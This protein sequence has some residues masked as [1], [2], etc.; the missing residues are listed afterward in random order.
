MKGTT[1]TVLLM[2]I[3][4]LV[5][6]PHLSEYL[7]LDL[8]LILCLIAAP[9]VFE[10]QNPNKFPVRAAWLAAI[11]L[12]LHFVLHMQ[13]WFL[14]AVGATLI[15][16][17]E[18]RHG[19]MGILPWI[20]LFL[21]T[22]MLNYL[23]GV[24]TFPIRLEMSSWAAEVLQTTGYPISVSGNLFT[25]NEHTFSVDQA[26][27]GL[28]TMITGL[29]ITVLLIAQGE[30]QANR[31]LPL[32]ALA[33]IFLTATA[34]LMLGNFV[35]IVMLA[36]F[37]SPPET[38]S[39]EVIG[40]LA[41]VSYLIVPIYFLIRFGIR[42]FGDVSSPCLL[43]RANLVGGE[44]LFPFAIQ[45]PPQAPPRRGSFLR[46]LACA[47]DSPPG[48]GL[49]WVY[50]CKKVKPY[51]ISQRGRKHTRNLHFLISKTL[52]PLLLIAVICYGSLNRKA[53]RAV[54]DPQEMA[55]IHIPGMK[56]SIVEDGIA[57]F[58]SP[59]LLVYVKP[60]RPFWRASHVPASCWQGSG[61][62]FK[63]IRTEMINGMLIYVA[64]LVKKDEKLYTA[65]WYDN[66]HI[67]T[68]SQWDWRWRNLK[69][70]NPFKL[71]NVTAEKLDF[72]RNACKDFL[73]S[74]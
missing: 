46:K 17:V 10:I 19:K 69:G 31:N 72:L 50:I 55:K 41:L 43:Q 54:G 7:Q 23:V 6:W 67:I 44:K 9:L 47:S 56:K 64:E 5:A 60:P 74:E 11:F 14:M 25:V 37:Q 20:L 28:N 27:I 68:H 22:P 52:V 8:P 62:Q 2:A 48:R 15:Y 18:S 70:E 16:L 24:F 3:C 29:V 61:F 13:V 33:G 51:K 63:H 39:H 1:G 38:F 73:S 42:R 32:W 66:D 21:L 30:K 59:G 35:R 57:K 58:E 36:L 34:L 40:L 71:V 65:W 53:F 45:N 4:L 12:A 26:C 49:G